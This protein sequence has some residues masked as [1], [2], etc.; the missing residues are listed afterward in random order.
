MYVQGPGAEYV[1]V[2]VRI[3]ST[4][5]RW[6][7]IPEVQF[8][9]V[10]SQSYGQQQSITLLAEPWGNLSRALTLTVAD[11][12]LLGD[13]AVGIVLGRAGSSSTPLPLA[14]LPVWR[15]AC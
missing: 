13:P 5:P 2:G 10:S 8:V 1:G 15:S 3:P 4:V 9:R 12:T 7:S 11:S 14:S 6:D